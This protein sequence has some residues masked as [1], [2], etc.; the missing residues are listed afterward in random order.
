VRVRHGTTRQQPQPVHSHAA[1]PVPPSGVR[2][3]TRVRHSL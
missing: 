3:R 1:A 2:P